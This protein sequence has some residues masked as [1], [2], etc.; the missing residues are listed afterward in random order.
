MKKTLLTLTLLF[1]ISI[2]A[3]AQT[4]TKKQ[5]IKTLFSLMH[6]DSLINKTFDAMSSSM[7]KQMATIFKDT[8]YKNA[9]INYSDRYAK[10]M[11]KSMEASKE[12]QRSLS[13]KTWLIFMTGILQ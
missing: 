13:M 4:E 2:Y 6:Q 10:I 3:H 7:A 12:M 8:L 5:K 9:G 11:Q 1:C